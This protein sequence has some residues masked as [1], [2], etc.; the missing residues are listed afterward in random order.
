MNI[1]IKLWQGNYSLVKTYWLFNVLVGMLLSIPTSLIAK[2]DNA[3]KL[4][5]YWLIFS[6]VCI[7][8]LY[9][10]IGLVGL[11]RSSNKYTG[12]KVL[13][14]LAKVVTCIGILLLPVTALILYD[15]GF[16]H[17]ITYILI[18][19]IG[20]AYIDNLSK[21]TKQENIDTF[22][23]KVDDEEIWSNLSNEFSS[24]ERKDGL[25]TMSLVEENGD[26]AK[27][28]I[29]Y[30]KL[31][32]EQIRNE[33]KI[34]NTSINHHIKTNSSSN[35]NNELL[36]VIAV[37]MVVLI[38]LAISNLPKNVTQ[39]SSNSTTRLPKQE[40]TQASKVDAENVD[41]LNFIRGILNEAALSKNEIK[42]TNLSV[43]EL[44]EVSAVK[45][46][47]K[48]TSLLQNKS[49]KLDDLSVTELKELK[50]YHEA[51]KKIQK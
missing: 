13:A 4:N 40:E 35:K 42:L 46:A 22:L 43:I 47:E 2:L 11:W 17:T 44:Q 26:E 48:N 25:W 51:I 38:A 36:I 37:V 45:S 39:F 3:T 8:G 33:N 12:N 9:A 19:V 10:F 21:N 28:K 16:L 29:K 18:I 31:R 30:L 27:A 23:N 34:S 6:F 20:S 1:L 14:L 32:Y 5:Y 49:I 24:S 50:A 15:A 41:K 7:S